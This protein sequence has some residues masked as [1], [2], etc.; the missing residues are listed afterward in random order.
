MEISSERLIGILRQY[1]P[2]W[3]GRSV[4]GLP[5]WQRAAFREVYSWMQS[6]PAPRAVL[7]SGARQTGKTTLAR[8]CIQ[9][10]LADG[11]PPRNILYV[12]LDEPLLKLS[13]LDAIV[14]LWQNSEPPEAGLRY[15]FLDEIQYARDWQTWLKLQV[16][17]HPDQRILVTGSATPLAT[18]RQESGVGRWHTIRLATLSFYEYLRIRGI[19]DMR[20]PPFEDLSDIA[21]LPKSDLARIG[22]NAQALVPFFNEYLMRGG[23]P[24][25]ALVASVEIAQ[26]LLREDIVDKV[27]KRDMTAIFGVRHIQEL[28]HLFL[29]L[30][31]H[32]GGLLDMKALCSSLH[33]NRQTVSNFLELLEAAHLIHRLRQYGY[34]KEVLRGKYKVYLTDA[35]IAPSVLLR[36]RAMLEDATEMGQAVETAVF[37][38]LCTQYQGAGPRF[39]YWRGKGGVEVDVIAEFGGRIMPFEVKYRE[40][41]TRGKN[42]R[43]IRQFCLERNVELGYVVTKRH[44][45]FEVTPLAPD[46]EGRLLKIPAPLFC[47]WLGESEIQTG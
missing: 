37:K 1:N 22:E 6:P 35:A 17:F 27:L 19:D 14:A 34:G 25:C 8:Q 30:C 43:G 18:E 15:L 45:D 20:V 13:D 23:F 39:S 41:D 5:Q 29:Y 24:Q 38:H 46:T 42:L 12:T 16:D 31:L 2:W 40:Q 9:Q 21:A 7:L 32:D 28:E 47:Y 44:S 36:G 3:N 10:L 4:S 26:R 11:V 33:L